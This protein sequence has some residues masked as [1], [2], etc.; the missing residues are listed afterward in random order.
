[1]TAVAPSTTK[2]KAAALRWRALLARHATSQ[3]QQHRMCPSPSSP[4][5]PPPPCLRVRCGVG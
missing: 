4:P 3:Q 1:M 5:P 2:A